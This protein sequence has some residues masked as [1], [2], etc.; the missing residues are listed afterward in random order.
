MKTQIGEVILRSKRYEA[1]LETN[2]GAKGSGLSEL[3][4][5]VATQ[6][7]YALKRNLYSI[8][9]MRNS[10]AHNPRINCIERVDL[11]ILTINEV[12]DEFKIILPNHAVSYIKGSDLETEV[13]Y[14]DRPAEVVIKE[15][16][17]KI[18]IPGPS[19]REKIKIY[20]IP[21]F[22]L[23]GS[24]LMVLSLVWAW[25]G[26]GFVSAHTN[27]E[28][29]ITR[30]WFWDSHEKFYAAVSEWELPL[31]LLIAGSIMCILGIIW[32]FITKN[33]NPTS[34]KQA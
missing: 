20:Q 26:T 7:P 11:F 1:I 17:K 16:I 3:T 30:G 22:I 8:A 25:L 12:E 27:E 21:Y 2:F 23:W 18:P 13:K 9:S 19:I 6:L 24:G 31:Y 34:R 15:V 32:H 14:Q 33:G 29:K 10:I 5:S 28:D 4:K